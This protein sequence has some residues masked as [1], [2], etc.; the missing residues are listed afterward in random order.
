MEEIQIRAVVIME[1][2]GMQIQLKY[3]KADSASRSILVMMLEASYSGIDVYI[4][5]DFGRK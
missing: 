4:Y 2:D 3:I 1:E 5:L